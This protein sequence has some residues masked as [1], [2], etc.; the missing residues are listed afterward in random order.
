MNRESEHLWK[1]ENRALSL[2]PY[3]LSWSTVSESFGKQV[4]EGGGPDAVR[5][6]L[7][8]LSIYKKLKVLTAQTEQSISSLVDEA[9]NDFLKKYK[10]K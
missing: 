7:H 2:F 6:Y 3:F 4:K 1:H 5:E 10:D 8:A 9:I